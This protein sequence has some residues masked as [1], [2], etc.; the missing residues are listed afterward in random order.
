MAQEAETALRISVGR[1]L[2]LFVYRTAISR[3]IDN[4]EYYANVSTI[5]G[6]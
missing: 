1:E 6:A 4:K 2:A 5:S 3:K